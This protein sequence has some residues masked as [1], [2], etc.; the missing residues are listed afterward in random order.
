VLNF[1]LNLEYLEAEFYLLATTGMSI[2][3]GQTTGGGQTGNTIGGSRVP[4]VTP[5]LARIAQDIASDM[6][7]SCARRSAPLRW[8]SRRST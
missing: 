4:F 7:S 5:R 1:A 6:S 8:Q 2:P 3:A